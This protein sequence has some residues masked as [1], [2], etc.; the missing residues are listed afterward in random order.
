MY[1]AHQ[2]QSSKAGAMRATGEAG[3]NDW[4]EKRRW[5]RV[6]ERDEMAEERWTR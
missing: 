5:K 6:R 2:R 4:M 1:K 3:R